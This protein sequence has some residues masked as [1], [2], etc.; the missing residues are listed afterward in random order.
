M[1][2]DGYFT[3]QFGKL[4]TIG[5]HLLF[6]YRSL[7]LKAD[8]RQQIAAAVIFL[9]LQ[10]LCYS[11]RLSYGS[12]FA[13]LFS[14][15]YAYFIFEGG[16]RTYLIHN[17]LFALIDGSVH[18]SVI[19]LFLSFPEAMR[20]TVSGT[21]IGQVMIMLAAKALLFLLSYFVTKEIK[22]YQADDNRDFFLIVLLPAGCFILLDVFLRQGPANQMPDTPPLPAVI[23]AALFLMLISTTMFC[24]R[25]TMD[26]KELLQTKLQLHLLE[27]KQAHMEQ[28]KS[29]YK[30]LSSV[31][32]DLHNHLEIIRGYL[33][34]KEYR[35]LKEYLDSLA[36]LTSN[37]FAYTN[38]QVLNILFSSRAA[39]A[40]QR[41]IEFTMELI[42][43]EKLPVCDVDLCI[44]ISNIL[45]NSFESSQASPAPR[46]IR[47]TTLMLDS[48]WVIACRNSVREKRNFSVSGKIKSS[49]A[50]S[51]RHGIG[52]RQ[53][54]EIAEKTGGFVTFKHSGHEFT[55]LVLLG[56]I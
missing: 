42:I 23:N 47:I 26:R 50:A 4:A 54:Q 41:E 35:M 52:T 45:D 30:K 8:L 13:L 18:I 22:D 33:N 12:Y 55:T 21:G 25:I 29:Q 32:H 37:Y 48:Y 40:A 31:R 11:H 51:G 20:E 15:I 9:M 34:A 2:M 17:L 36:V 10:M 1:R 43:P 16:V 38:N 46:F 3:A 53:I 14:V 39:L 7:K 56:L 49:K 19:N 24:R 27:M 44:L 28:V 5:L 6:L